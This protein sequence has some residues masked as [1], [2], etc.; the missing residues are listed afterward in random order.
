MWL[1]CFVAYYSNILV[2]F[3]QRDPML[4]NSWIEVA[5]GTTNQE[6]ETNFESTDECQENMKKAQE[7]LMGQYLYKLIDLLLWLMP[8]QSTR[9]APQFL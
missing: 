6:V 7:K 4:L 1:F 2:H 9:G 5:S 8:L 3:L